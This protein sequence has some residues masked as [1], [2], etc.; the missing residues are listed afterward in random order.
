[1]KSKEINLNINE[2][3]STKSRVKS[4]V[5]LCTE[6]QPFYL[7][8]FSLSRG[9]DSVIF[10]GSGNTVFSQVSWNNGIYHKCLASMV[11]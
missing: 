5:G 7:P 8:Y 4:I 6:H 10:E 9:N 2:E 1:M 11:F 3:A